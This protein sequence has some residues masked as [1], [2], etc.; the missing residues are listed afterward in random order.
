MTF[1][2]MGYYQQVCSIFKFESFNTAHQKKAFH[3]IINDKKDVFVNLTTGAGNHLFITPLAK[4]FDVIFAYKYL[5]KLPK[6]CK[7]LVLNCG[8]AID[9]F[10]ARSSKKTT[11]SRSQCCVI[12]IKLNDLNRERR[13]SECIGRRELFCI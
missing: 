2:C 3:S 13:R 4:L 12:N 8:F 9:K 1:T 6:H 11:Q 7:H 5:N 10:N